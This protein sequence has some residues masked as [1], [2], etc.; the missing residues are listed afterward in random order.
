MCIRD[1]IHIATAIASAPGLEYIMRLYPDAHIWTGAIDEE[2]TAKSYIVPGLGDAGDL[3]F[4]PKIQ[5]WP[6]SDKDSRGPDF[7]SGVRSQACELAGTGAIA[8]PRIAWAAGIA[9]NNTKHLSN[10][11]DF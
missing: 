8:Y 10:V 2:L 7:W 1:R 11:V 5:D 4:G 9:Q 3:S 6:K